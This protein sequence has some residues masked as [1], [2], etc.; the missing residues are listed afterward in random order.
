MFVVSSARM[1]RTKEFCKTSP[2]ST[3]RRKAGYST[4]PG[5]LC[6]SVCVPTLLAPSLPAFRV[7]Y[8][9]VLSLGVNRPAHVGVFVQVGERMQMMGLVHLVQITECLR[10][11]YVL[12]FAKRSYVVIV[13]LKMYTL[14]SEL[15]RGATLPIG[16]KKTT[17]V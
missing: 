4:K 16:P 3:H 13:A 7:T 1:S 2:V 11:R 8:V 10:H 5:T 17:S 6:L 12:Q 9:N 15:G 14:Q